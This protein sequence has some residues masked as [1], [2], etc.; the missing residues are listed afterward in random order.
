MITSV[1]GPV[2]GTRQR[3]TTPWSSVD[4]IMYLCMYMYARPIHNAVGLDFLIGFQD[5]TVYN[6]AMASIVS[7]LTL[8]MFGKILYTK[9]PFFVN[10]G[11]LMKNSVY[12]IRNDSLGDCMLSAGFQ[13]LS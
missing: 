13:G 12:T 4:P 5:Q 9:L 10:F 7:P 11:I 8:V 1:S 2:N 3:N 6:I